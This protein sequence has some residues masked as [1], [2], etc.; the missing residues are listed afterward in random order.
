MDEQ[1]IGL[2]EPKVV[3]MRRKERAEAARL[4]A[5]LILAARRS[6]EPPLSLPPIPNDPASTLP[7]GRGANGNLSRPKATGGA[8]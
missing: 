2:E 1:R 8:G 4:L 7:L 6:R 5:T 3:P